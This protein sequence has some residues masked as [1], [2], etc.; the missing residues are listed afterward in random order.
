MKDDKPVWT[1]AECRRLYRA[2][3]ALAHACTLFPDMPKAPTQ[4]QLD[5]AW[6]AILDA[7]ETPK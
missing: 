2:F 4:K 6:N 3:V 7:P 5:R 1:D